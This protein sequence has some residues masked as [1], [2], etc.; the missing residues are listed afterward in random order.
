M[1]YLI[2]RIYAVKIDSQKKDH[3]TGVEFAALVLSQL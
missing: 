1:C 3:F 2:A